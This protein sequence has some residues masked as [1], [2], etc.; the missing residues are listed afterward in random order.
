MKHPWSWLVGLALFA[1]A[2]GC[3]GTA[4]SIDRAPAEDAMQVSSPVAT[5]V[6]ATPATFEAAIGDTAQVS[7]WFSAHNGEE[8]VSVDGWLPPA[9]WGATH[10]DLTV[11]TGPMKDGL[12]TVQ[13]TGV[14]PPPDLTAGTVSLTFG[15][16]VVSGEMR[17]GAD[18]TPWTL[19]GKMSVECWVPRPAG[20]P[21]VNGTNAPGA[22]I[23]DE[24]LASPQCAPF[25]A[26]AGH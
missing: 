3:G 2:A 7:V 6:S 21:I 24:T 15:V 9:S 18:Q 20:T 10:V 12:A 19:T 26:L 17:L 23:A 8:L 14:T 5:F 4:T 16:G 11:S 25:R 13:T 1:T 22:L